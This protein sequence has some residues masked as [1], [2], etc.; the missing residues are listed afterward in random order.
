MID[1]SVPIAPWST[2]SKRERSNS[3]IAVKPVKRVRFADT[4]TEFGHTDE[5]VDTAFGTADPRQDIGTGS[6]WA[7][8]SLNAQDATPANNGADVFF[9][10]DQPMQWLL[11]EFD[12]ESLPWNPTQGS[13]YA[14]IDLTPADYSV[15]FEQDES[16]W[17]RVLSEA[18][19]QDDVVPNMNENEVAT[20][21]EL[22]EL[23]DNDPDWLR[24]AI[25]G[26]TTSESQGGSS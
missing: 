23:V 15:E 20:S 8:W 21:W 13:G 22:P 26:T 11:E 7:D 24:E 17:A 4:V 18:T 9:T 12:L 5:T 25:W 2:G 3:A 10:V 1:A 19:Y 14:P 6:L 16:E